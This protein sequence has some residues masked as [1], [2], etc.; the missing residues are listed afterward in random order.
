MIFN[1]E[2]K[3]PPIA[4]FVFF[5]LSDARNKTK[6]IGDKPFYV[7]SDIDVTRIQRVI[8]EKSALKSRKVN[9]DKCFRI[10]ES[11]ISKLT[12]VSI[13]VIFELLVR[14]LR[15]ERFL[16]LEISIAHRSHRLMGCAKCTT[17]L[18]TLYGPTMLIVI[19]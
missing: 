4:L 11:T 5:R 8:P 9:T 16:I 1:I 3:P 7:K 10:F 18:L 12:L 6:N 15:K 2:K 14:K 19:N 17:L 13:S